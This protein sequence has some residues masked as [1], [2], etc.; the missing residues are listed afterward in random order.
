MGQAL[1]MLPDVTGCSYLVFQPGLNVTFL[2]AV[3]FGHDNSLI[4]GRKN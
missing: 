4:V 2:S 1:E 3:G